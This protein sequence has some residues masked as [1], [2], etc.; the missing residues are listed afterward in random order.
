MGA[1]L[2]NGF[3]ASPEDIDAEAQQQHPTSPG[4]FKGFLCFS[5]GRGSFA[6]AIEHCARVQSARRLSQTP[7]YESV[8]L[9]KHTS[10]EKLCQVKALCRYATVTNFGFVGQLCITSGT[11]STHE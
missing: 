11:S 4:W 10:S 7:T 6:L 5:W 2:N 8:A 3:K 1:A 9:K